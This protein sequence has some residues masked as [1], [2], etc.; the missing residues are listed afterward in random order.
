[1]EIVL[2]NKVAIVTGSI[3]G[4]GRA[5]AEILAANGAAVVVNNHQDPV[6]LEAVAEGIRKNGG[7]AT[8]V[9]AD[10]TDRSQVQKL[11]DA[12]LELGGLDILI[13]NAGGLI[14]RVPVAEFEDGHFQTVMDVN[15]KTAFLMSSLVLPQM[16]K[17]K[18]GKII[19]FSSQ[20][21]HDGGGPGAA[22]YAASKGAIWTFTKSLA[23]EVAPF[24]ITV[25]C[26]SP[27]FI[28]NTAFHNTFTSREAHEKMPNVIPQGRLGTV[29][30]VAR[31][32]FF[33]ASEL[34]DYMTGQSI[35]VNG[36][37]YMP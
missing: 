17:Q 10:I 27:G 24:G 8:A 32:V 2:K 35:E 18:S 30:D 20:A 5:T 7:K 13:N 29:E 14:K 6:E 25:N 34:S 16:K 21:A 19:H 31:V 23:K 37:L 1:M 9:L 26:V 28:A 33:L 15:V 36:G 4:I 12:A 11:V 22:A 3:Q